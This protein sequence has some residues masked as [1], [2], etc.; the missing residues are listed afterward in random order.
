MCERKKYCTISKKL[1]RENVEG[2]NVEAY[3]KM[4]IRDSP[5]D[6][7]EEGRKK[8]EANLLEA[9]DEAEYMGAKGIAF[10]AGKWQEETKE[11]AYSQLLKTTRNLCTYAATKGCL[12]YT[13]RCV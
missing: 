7:D 10:L 13:S 3:D 9:I 8:A 6:I 12:L 2:R 4:C 1:L 5:N 11:E